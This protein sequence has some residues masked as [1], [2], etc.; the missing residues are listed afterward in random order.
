M[1][2]V[3]MQNGIVVKGIMQIG[4]TQELARTQMLNPES[5]NHETKVWMSIYDKIQ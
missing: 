3:K 2:L 1:Q 4:I 5:T